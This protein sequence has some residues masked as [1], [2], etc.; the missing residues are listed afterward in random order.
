VT[1]Y[2]DHASAAP[3]D[4]RV[5]QAM[6]DAVGTLWADPESL[7]DAG[8]APAEAL[9]TARAQIAALIGAEPDDVIFT[10]GP[11]ESRNLAV[12]GLV[13][14]NRALGARIVASTVEHPVTHAVLQA[15]ERDGA[16]VV[17][18]GVDGDGYLDPAA[19]AAA[20]DDETSV[21]T[22][23]HGQS[24]IGTIQPVGELIGAARAA[25][26]EV[27]IHL[28]A[29]DTAGVLPIGI[30][31]LDALTLGGPALGAPRWVG[32][33]WVRPG[34]RLHPLMVG[35]AE[36]MGKRP[37]APDLP[38]IVALGVA[39]EIAVQEAAA[40]VVHLRRLGARLATGLA[41]TARVRLNGPPPDQRLPGHVQVSVGDV[42]AQSLVLALAGHGVA[43]APGSACSADARKAAPT[44][45]AI[46]LEAPWTHSAV[47]FTAGPTTTE[48]E[49]D[50]AITAFAEAVAHLRS[51]STLRG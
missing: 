48:A 42:E 16:T 40:H 49:I 20:I 13:A 7:H 45:E 28:D 10:S 22:I 39:A 25:R 29:A 36:E 19:V 11:T 4:P 46:G 24:E 33:L 17:R 15:L 30:E 5:A 6:A 12:R 26:P 23:T 43:C 47:L 21:L 8:R 31:G 14:G 37:G 2:L 41:A 27:R 18:V 35:G 51:M 38:A 32:A 44:L 1:A 50:H 34:A 3:L 9:E